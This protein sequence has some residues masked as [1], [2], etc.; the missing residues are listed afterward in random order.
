MLFRFKIKKTAR[1]HEPNSCLSWDMKDIATSGL[2]LTDQPREYNNTCTL[3]CNEHSN[4]DTSWTNTMQQSYLFVHQD[5]VILRLESEK[6]KRNNPGIHQVLTAESL[7]PRVGPAMSG[8]SCRKLVHHMAQ[9]N[10]GSGRGPWIH[11]NQTI[12]VLREHVV[13][14]RH[15]HSQ[16]MSNCRQSVRSFPVQNSRICSNM[17]HMVKLEILI[18]VRT[19]T[20]NKSKYRQNSKLKGHIG[21]F[22][23]ILIQDPCLNLHKFNILDT[24][25]C[26]SHQNECQLLHFK[27]L[28]LLCP[29]QIHCV[30]GMS[31]LWPS[32]KNTHKSSVTSTIE[33][34]ACWNSHQEVTLIGTH[35]VS[36]FQP[37]T[38]IINKVIAKTVH[39]KFFQDHF[40][41]R[42]FCFNLFSKLAIWHS[43]VRNSPFCICLGHI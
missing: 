17:A 15:G 12:Y 33:A 39:S 19:I 25:W 21:S 11:R 18:H 30:P 22:K 37:Y 28:N 20:P 41:S 31:K 3:T 13:N 10:Q 5:M 7:P 43:L 40:L 38:P 9:E 42:P 14:S 34:A 24:I 29:S 27:F 4:K 8:S 2:Y 32:V 23:T 35:I 6:E 16:F 26:I 1:T 36:K